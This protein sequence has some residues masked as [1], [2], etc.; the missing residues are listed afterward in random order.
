MT[1]AEFER[2]VADATGESL[3]TI[4]RHGFGLMVVLDREPLTVDWDDLPH[5]DPER[6]CRPRRRHSQAA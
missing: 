2:E 6:A 3:G 1:Q 4:R 5:R